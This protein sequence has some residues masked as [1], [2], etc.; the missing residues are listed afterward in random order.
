MERALV[1]PTSRYRHG[2][3]LDNISAI[4]TAAGYEFTTDCINMMVFLRDLDDRETFDRVMEHYLSTSP[5]ARSVLQS[6]LIETALKIQ[7][8]FARGSPHSGL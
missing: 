4:A 7:A 2:Q 8:V 3:A 1:M 5:P 6:H